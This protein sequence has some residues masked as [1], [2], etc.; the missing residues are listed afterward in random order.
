MGI[1]LKKIW[2]FIWYN[3]SPASWLISLVLVFIL[4]K[5]ILYPVIGLVFGTGYP[6]VAVVSW[7][8]EH[9]GEKFDDWWENNSEWYVENEITK[10]KFLEFKLKNGFNQGDVMFVFGKNAENVNL[11][12]VIVFES[13]TNY[14]VIHRVVKIWQTEE[15]YHFK[16]K[17]DN[18]PKSHSQLKEVDIN[19]ERVIGVASLRIPFIGWVKIIFSR[20]IETFGRLV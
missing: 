6:I 3:D 8:M 20:V 4:V 13:T 12:D 2:R 7:S 1:N 16:T 17:G 5:F 11:G 18:N 9:D 15:G 10:E 14:P 19:E